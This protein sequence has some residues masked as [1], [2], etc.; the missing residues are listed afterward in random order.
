[1]M[2]SMG[3][4]GRTPGTSQDSCPCCGPMGALGRRQAFGLGGALAATLW[5][6]SPARAASGNYEAMLVNCIDPRFAS[7]SSDYMAARGLRGRFSQ[8]VIA[9]G[10]I[11]A[12]HPRFA[13]WHETFWENLAVSVDLHRI[14]RVVAL[15]HRDCGAA[16]LAFG[17]AAV[18]APAAEQAAHHECLRQFAAEVRRRHPTLV[19]DAGLTAASGAVELVH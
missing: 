9:G 1:M 18:A 8:F 11:G 10:P 13:G 3:H 15:T 5:A 14:Q 19:V 12:V 16:K 4:K 6:G 17:D 7:P 2:R